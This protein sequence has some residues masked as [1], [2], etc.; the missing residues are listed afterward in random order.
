MSAPV[1]PT[2]AAALVSQVA[3]NAGAQP[4]S[5]VSLTKAVHIA[6]IETDDMVICHPKIIRKKEYMVFEKVVIAH[7]LND[8]G[9][10]KITKL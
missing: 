2:G 3:K 6:R 4:I 8:A 9:E 10:I 7:L 5:P 1:D